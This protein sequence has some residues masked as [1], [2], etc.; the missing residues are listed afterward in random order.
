MA[1]LES[2]SS[3][4]PTSDSFTTTG[5]LH[6]ERGRSRLWS[7]QHFWLQLQLLPTTLNATSL[8]R[9]WKATRSLLHALNKA[10]TCCMQDEAHQVK[11]AVCSLVCTESVWWALRQ[12]EGPSLL[13]GGQRLNIYFSGREAQVDQGT[14]MLMCRLSSSGT[15]CAICRQVT[16]VERWMNVWCRKT[17]HQT[18]LGVAGCN[19]VEHGV[20][21]A[22]DQLERC[23]KLCEVKIQTKGAVGCVEPGVEEV[24]LPGTAKVKDLHTEQ[25]GCCCAMKLQGRPQKVRE[26]EQPVSK[27]AAAAFARRYQ[28]AEGQRLEV[29]CTSPPR[30]TAGSPVL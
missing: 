2:T 30:P 26:P 7:T 3:R 11:I 19:T 9:L 21:V 24:G 14:A 22:L 28:A 12:T 6:V 27:A 25:P 10:V 23:V 4:M 15:C 29:G 8:H 13:Q 18:D 1:R 17:Q 16:S 5:I 20:Q